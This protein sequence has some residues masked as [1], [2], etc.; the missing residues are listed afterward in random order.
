MADTPSGLDSVNAGSKYMTDALEAQSRMPTYNR[1]AEQLS[2]D[3]DAAETAANALE[4]RYANPN[5]FKVAAGFLKPQLGGFAA[6]LG[7]AGQAMGE[8]QEQQRNNALPVYQA[9][10]QVALMKAQRDNK[11]SA[12]ADVDKW[13]SNG[14]KPEELDALT[15]KLNRKGAPDLA[16]ALNKGV[17]TRTAVI[18]Q[19]TAEQ[20]Q[21]LKAL[22]DLLASGAIDREEFTRRKAAVTGKVASASGNAAPVAPFAAA[23]VAPVAAAPANSAPAPFNPAV[24]LPSSEVLTASQNSRPNSDRVGIL[25]DELTKEKNILAAYPQGS[26]P[27]DVHRTQTNIDALQEQLTKLGGGAAPASAEAKPTGTLQEKMDKEDSEFKK[28]YTPTYSSNDPAMRFEAKTPSEKLAQSNII[29]KAAIAEKEPLAEFNNLAKINDSIGIESAQSATQN[30]L[31]MMKAR[32]DLAA[33]VTNLLRQ[34]GPLAAMIQSGGGINVL[35]NGASFKADVLAGLHAKLDS[36]EEQKFLDSLMN[37]MATATYYDMLSKGMDPTKVGA[38]RFGQNMLQETGINQ[39]AGAIYH[40]LEN[41]NTRLKQGKSLYKA[42]NDHVPEA[43][44]KGSLSPYSDIK[45]MHP[46]IERANAIAKARLDKA[47]SDYNSVYAP[48]KATP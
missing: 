36:K 39:G 38:E 1:T 42:Y 40:S 48:K 31:D 29:D 7:S 6:S 37:S 24:P 18:E 15:E 30:V 28:S 27:E 33:K 11:L 43:V 34:A 3:T 8:W 21:Q 16:E 47:N 44:A 17:S 19:G 5:W 14:R 46:A 26:N 2:S 22:D 35:G 23:P 41:I 4:Q 12:Q 32:P 13:V 10:A 20:N 25:A 45:S 9:R